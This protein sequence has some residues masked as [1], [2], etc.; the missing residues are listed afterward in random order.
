MIKTA[1]EKTA[2]IILKTKGQAL[3]TQIAGKPFLSLTSQEK[4]QILEYLWEKDK[5]F[6][7]KIV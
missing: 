5:T 6:S 4:D 3:Q 7:D 2:E 1:G